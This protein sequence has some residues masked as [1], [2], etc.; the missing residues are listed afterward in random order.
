[1]ALLS[2]TI[3]VKSIYLFI[4]IDMDKMDSLYRICSLMSEV[5]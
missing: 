3:F 2:K 4:Q 5:H 1:M